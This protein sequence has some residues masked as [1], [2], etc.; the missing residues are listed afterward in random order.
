MSSSLDTETVTALTKTLLH[1][2][3]EF[4]YLQ[5]YVDSDDELLRS[6][7]IHAAEA[8]N[9]KILTH[10]EH[11]DAGFDLYTPNQVNV[12]CGLE[13]AKIDFNIICRAY[14][15]SKRSSATICHYNTGF[16]MYPRS[17][18]CK[19]RL[20]L[21]N[22]VGIID[23]GYRGHLIGAFD[24]P[25]IYLASTPDNIYQLD[26]LVQICA[27]GLIPIMV[28]IVDTKEQLGDQTVRG[29]GGFGSTGV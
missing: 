28:E 13:L 2:Y 29:E 16:Y 6:T 5:I 24:V 3:D 27:P 15:V 20:R 8:H 12:T 21:A 9:T 17:S 25:R 7:Y 22:N 10:P 19:T 1:L 26:R 18:I 14:K 4:M 23:S 11:I